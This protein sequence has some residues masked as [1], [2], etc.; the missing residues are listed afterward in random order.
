MTRLNI[1]GQPSSF[2][3]F[4]LFDQQQKEKFSRN[5]GANGARTSPITSLITIFFF[6][7]AWELVCQCCQTHDIKASDPC[8]SSNTVRV[9]NPG[10][11]RC[12]VLVLLQPI[13]VMRSG[14]SVDLWAK[15]F[16]Q[17]SNYIL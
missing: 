8:S 9:L 2:D 3:N 1:N 15:T 10:V 11:L 5:F 4:F 16:I 7:S 14:C 13:M 12:L 6:S 17:D